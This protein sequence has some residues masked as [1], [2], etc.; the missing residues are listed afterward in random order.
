MVYVYHVPCPPLNAYIDNIYYL[1]E[2]ALFSRL[3]V[4]P[5]PAPI[6]MINFADSF[7]VYQPNQS[8][9]IVTCSDS[10][11]VGLW[12]TYHLV[13]WP[14]H[15]HCFGIHFKSGGAYPFLR[16]PL[17]ELNNQVVPLD[18]VYGRFAVELRERL[19]AAPTITAGFALLEELLLARLCDTLPGLDVVQYAIAEIV[20]QQGV[21]SIPALSDRIGISQNHLG[22]LFKRMVGIPVK[23]FARFHRLG[24]ILRSMDPTQPMNWARVAH[25][26]LYYDQAHF[27]RDFSAFTGHTPGDYLR[28]RHQMNAA[29]PQHEELL[30]L[31][32]TD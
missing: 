26:F 7:H 4:L 16:R 8:D 1:D 24:H 5:R 30:Q 21:L 14:P 20:Q 11:W 15:T 9:A 32:P 19:Y 6:L 23:E 18:A 2:P 3:K 31:L 28:L 10:W 17:S 25:Q 12:S 27:T 29:E 13:D 22:T